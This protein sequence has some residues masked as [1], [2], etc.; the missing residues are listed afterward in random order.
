MASLPLS[1]NALSHPDFAK[2]IE[3]AHQFPVSKPLKLISPSQARDCLKEQ[4]IEARREILSR[5]TPNG[6]I[7][8]ALDCWTSK[9]NLSFLAT[10]G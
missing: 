7:A 6:K 8:I 4:V 1:Y 2:L 10:T 5:M 9:N 3:M